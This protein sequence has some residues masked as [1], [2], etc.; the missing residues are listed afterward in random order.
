MD[1]QN[2]DVF[3]SQFVVHGRTPLVAREKS[4][5]SLWSATIIGLVDKRSCLMSTSSLAG[6]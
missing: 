3:P 4:L 6:I 2:N 1:Q 5:G